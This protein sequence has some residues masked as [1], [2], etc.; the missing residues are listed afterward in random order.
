MKKAIFYI[1]F[2]FAF[3]FTFGQI[4]T[5]I[6][7]ANF[8]I[9]ADLRSNFFGGVVVSGNDDWFSKADA[10]T[11]DF[12][13]DTTGAAAIISGYSSNPASRFYSFA[14]G[15]RYPMLSTINGKIYY[16]ASYVRDYHGTDSTGFGGG[17][18]N[19]QSPASWITTISPVPSKNDILETYLHVR[20]DGTTTAD[21]LWFFGAVSIQGTTGDRYFDFELYQTDIKF[22]R[23]TGKFENYGPDA[24]HTSWKFDAAG[25]ISQLGDIIFT[26]EYGT[27]GLTFI[28]ARVWVNKT[29]L[30]TI[31]P[32]AFDWVTPNVFDGDGSGATYGYA[33]IRPKSGGN[34]YQG[35]Q[36]SDSTWAGPFGT[37]N[38]GDNYVQKYSP[39]QF[40]EF[41]VN[42]TRLGLDPMNFTSGSMCNLA[43]GKVLVK[44]RTST[45]FTSSISDFVSPFSFRAIAN[46]DA[47]A[48][49][50]LL[51]TTN[52]VATIRVINPLSTSTYLWS[53]TNGHFT[54][55][56]SG[57]SVTVDSPGTYVVIQ[58]LLSG[59]S[60]NGRDSV[61]ISRNLNNSCQILSSKL[62]SFTAAGSRNNVQLKWTIANN[63][64]VAGIEVERADETGNYS[65]IA[66]VPVDMA[67]SSV[68]SYNYS[69][70]LFGSYST[71]LMYRIK[72]K[73]QNG[74]VYYSEVKSLKFGS[75]EKTSVQ[76]NPNPVTNSTMNLLITVPE[77]TT[78][79][80]RF[81]NSSGLA[82]FAEKR[83]LEQGVNNIR[84]QGSTPWQAGV[85][86][87]SV[88]TGNETVF[89]KV[90]VTR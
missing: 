57:T 64:S 20:R 58:Q 87:L 3:S 2:L 81:T 10:G 50:P 6:V 45:S 71:Q 84:I 66:Q 23:A 82:V 85:Y 78:G 12:V 30:T 36:N 38:S 75:A 55:P 70:N 65:S 15:M 21:S 29:A 34:F 42:L 40:M 72:I 8:G 83:Q 53:T 46:V 37:I 59:C 5:P 14:R 11:G 33:S 80:I 88:K 69:D 41:S 4:T 24:G 48:D 54:T 16:D 86:I 89:S 39:V 63:S 44:T 62:Q 35:L 52:N 26:A 61:V 67:S 90:L 60:E 68:A 77:K 13:I 73:E 9:E 79:E 1:V 47:R 19:G 76:V 56:V 27:A 28:E 32:T 7:K 49:F 17:S 18:K 31:T 43:F 74:S 25:N 51:C 22:N